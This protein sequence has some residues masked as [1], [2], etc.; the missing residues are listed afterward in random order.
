[1]VSD[2]SLIGLPGGLAGAAVFLGGSLV[3]LLVFGR[4]LVSAIIVS[5]ISGAAASLVYWLLAR[6]DL[7]PA[8]TAGLGAIGGAVIAPFELIWVKF[9]D[10]VAELEAASDFEYAGLGS[11][12]WRALSAALRRTGER[13]PGGSAH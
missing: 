10:E 9:R 2:A 5:A 4:S 3:V 6:P 13:E 12:L 7:D 11:T 1:L 8:G